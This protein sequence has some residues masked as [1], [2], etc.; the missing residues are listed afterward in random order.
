MQ[1]RGPR[2]LRRSGLRPD[3]RLLRSRTLNSKASTYLRFC[4][5]VRHSTPPDTRGT[6]G[7]ACLR[8]V[9]YATAKQQGI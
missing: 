3:P 4:I 5:G 6:P 7:W 1:G 2:S 8:L 9:G